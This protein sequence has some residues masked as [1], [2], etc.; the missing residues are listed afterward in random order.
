MGPDEGYTDRDGNR[1][2]MFWGGWP[3]KLQSTMAKGVCR[4]PLTGQLM[5]VVYLQPD[6]GVGVMFVDQLFPNGTWR[7]QQVPLGTHPSRI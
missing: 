1:C 4:H 3:D 6:A 7:G 5:Y 2:E